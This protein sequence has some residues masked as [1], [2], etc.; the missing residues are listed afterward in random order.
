MHTIA[1]SGEG[2]SRS[3]AEGLRLWGGVPAES[4]PYFFTQVDSG[5]AYQIRGFID[6]RAEFDPFFDFTQ[7]PR[8]GDSF[9]GY[10]ERAGDGS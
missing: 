6:T 7:Q 10:V 8:A 4:A 3:A 2:G 5:R 9:G 1:A